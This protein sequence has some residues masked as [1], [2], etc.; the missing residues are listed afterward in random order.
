[1]LR[2][3]F[4]AV[5]IL[6]VLVVK[7]LVVFGAIVIIVEVVLVGILSRGERIAAVV[8]HLVRPGATID[9]E[10]VVDRNVLERDLV[11]PRSQACDQRR[12]V[13]VA[14]RNHIVAI[15]GGDVGMGDVG[16][17]DQ[18]GDLRRIGRGKEQI[19]GLNTAEGDA[20]GA[21]A[22]IDAEPV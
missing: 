13:R 21:S 2:S 17:V 20:V 5:V 18:Q 4:L 8:N 1:M 12:K 6:V 22:G 7:I 3:I 11:V 9:V 16:V 15:A 19:D 10:G 14:D